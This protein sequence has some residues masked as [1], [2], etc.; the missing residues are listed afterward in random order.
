MLRQDEPRIR[1][2]RSICL[3]LPF[4]LL[5]AAGLA[6]VLGA[7]TPATE[8]VAPPPDAAPPAADSSAA[9]L[10]YRNAISEPPPGWTGPVFTLSHDYPS[11]LD[12]CSP[13]VCTW[14]AVDVDFDDPDPEWSYWAP[15][16]DAILA[17]VK[18]GQDLSPAGWNTVVGTET[19]WFHVPWMAYDPKA[20]R[21]FVHGFTNERTASLSDFDGDGDIDEA[22][23]GYNSL[24]GAA[25]GKE[26]ESW[27]VGMYNPWGGATVGAAWNPQGEPVMTGNPAQPAG[28]PFPEGT[29]VVKILFTTATPADVP[30]LEGS[31]EWQADRHVELGGCVR[32]PQ[33]VRLVQMDVAVVDERSPTHWVYGTFGYNGT[34][35]GVSVWERMSPIGLQWGN[36]PESWPA[37]PES[38][39]KPIHQSVMAPIDIYEHLGCGNE[40]IGNRLAGPVDN[41]QSACLACHAGGYAPR[42][43]GTVVVMGAPPA[44]NAPPIFGFETLCE[45][46]DQANADY[47]A[48]RIFPAGYPGYPDDFSTDSSLQLQVAYEQFANFATNG[49]P[50]KCTPSS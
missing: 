43:A 31:P 12:S 37:V 5:A 46:A 1:R 17:Y 21:E 25:A 44:G 29:L 13:E 28:L 26:F 48:N 11:A 20:G 3:T 7:C 14:L 27:A 50:N 16:L 4:G 42:P 39:S 34:L 40:A 23:R 38:S 8:E 24:P 10:A 15:Y 32:A 19:R 36:D 2:T 47:F 41:P 18:E 30:Y 49:E 35:E 33:P 9:E 6:L 45:K 22:R